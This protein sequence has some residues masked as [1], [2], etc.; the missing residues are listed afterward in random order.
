MRIDHTII[1]QKNEKL[2]Q[3]NGYQTM[4]GNSKIQEQKV[5]RGNG[6][7]PRAVMEENLITIFIT[8]TY[9]HHLCRAD[10]KLL[11]TL[12]FALPT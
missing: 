6:Q 12:K 1:L 10:K 3:Q 11:E 7:L 5:D 9:H 2:E 4:I 8:H